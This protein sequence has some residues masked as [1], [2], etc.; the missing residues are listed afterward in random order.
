MARE[1][2]IVLVTS[3]TQRFD[4]KSVGATLAKNELLVAARWQDTEGVHVAGSSVKANAFLEEQ[5]GVPGLWEVTNISRL[6]NFEAWEKE[7]YA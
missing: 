2:K 3:S 7:Q 4:V 6:E 5:A 1:I